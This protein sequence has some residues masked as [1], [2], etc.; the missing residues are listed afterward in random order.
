MADEMARVEFL[1]AKVGVS[2]AELTQVYSFSH[3]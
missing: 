2:E 1:L 3:T